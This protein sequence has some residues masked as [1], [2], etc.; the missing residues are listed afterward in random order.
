LLLALFA[1][2]G[3]FVERLAIILN[4]LRRDYLPSSWTYYTPEWGPLLTGFLGYTLMVAL[5]SI[6]IKERE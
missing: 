2:S 5:T 3:I 4:T 6:F 1:A